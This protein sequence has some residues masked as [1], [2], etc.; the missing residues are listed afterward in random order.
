MPTKS[1]SMQLSVSIVS[2]NT[3]A[4][5]KR[6][7]ASIFKFTKGLSFEVIVV[8]NGSTDD[9]AAIVRKDFPQVKL[10]QNRTNRWYSGANNQA[11]NAAKGKY[12][13]ILNSDIFLKDN[14][15]KSLVCYL[16]APESRRCRAVAAVRE[17]ENYINRF[18][19]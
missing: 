3:K 10:I 17:R 9:S 12:F 14:A 8:D 2:F 13:L 16:P 15:F 5:L 6:C 7:L 11:L 19:A 4:L 18:P 1:V